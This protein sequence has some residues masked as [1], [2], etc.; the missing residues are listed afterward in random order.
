MR[1]F[2]LSLVTATLFFSCSSD[3]SSGDSQNPSDDN[4]SQMTIDNTPITG[5]WEVRKK[6]SIASNNENL[7][8]NDEIPCGDEY[9][10]KWIIED[11]SDLPANYSDM[12]AFTYIY[13]LTDNQGI[14]YEEDFTT[15]SY[16]YIMRM[17][18]KVIRY[19][20]IPGADHT[21][22]VEFELLQKTSTTMMLKSSSSNAI[23]GRHSVTYVVKVE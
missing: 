8:L 21:Y 16:P 22:T 6:G 14:C 15:S 11:L 3:D 1:K 9:Y 10:D 19:S 17:G 7:I 13:Y 12:K 2:L 23:G 18:K 20:W 5:T 4:P